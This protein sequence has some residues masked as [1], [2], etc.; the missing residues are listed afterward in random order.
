MAP[1]PMMAP[2]GQPGG[3]APGVGIG[4]LQSAGVGAGPRKRNPIMVLL[5]PLAVMIGGLVFFGVL[6]GVLQ[7]PAI[8]VLGFLSYLAGLGLFFFNTIQMANELKTVTRSPGFAW[9]PILVPIYGMYWAWILV[10]QE[11]AKAKQMLGVQIPVRSIVLYIFLWPFALAS[12]IND[13]AR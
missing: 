4:T 8:F 7:V 5:L 2:Y 6:A 9:W 1:G 3:M 10:P 13:M 12:D 11:V